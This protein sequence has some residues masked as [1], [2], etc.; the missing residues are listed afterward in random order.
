MRNLK[1]SIPTPEKKKKEEILYPPEVFKHKISRSQNW[2]EENLN[3]GIFCH[4]VAYS[5]EIHDIEWSSLLGGGPPTS[6]NF[7]KK[8]K[9]EAQTQT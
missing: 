8:E 1:N 3:L 5:A 2:V 9:A 4:P 7:T 6:H